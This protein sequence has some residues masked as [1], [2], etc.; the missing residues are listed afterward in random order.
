MAL[1]LAYYPSQA[2]KPPSTRQLRYGEHTDWQCFTIVAQ[3]K[4][5]LEVEVPCSAE[6]YGEAS[7]DR[8]GSRENSMFVPCTPVPGALTVNAGDQIQ[9]LT[10]GIFRSCVHRV[11]NPDPSDATARMSPHSSRPRPDA[12]LAP[13]AAPAAEVGADDRATRRRRSLP[14]RRVGCVCFCRLLANSVILYYSR[15][16]RSRTGSGSRRAE[17]SP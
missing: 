17:G 5:G 12:R 11:A 4:Q 2:G 9:I 7:E 10:N 6:A 8:R 1:R 16:H 3:D 15:R 14:R 13:L